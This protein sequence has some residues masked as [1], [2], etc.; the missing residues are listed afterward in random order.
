MC[1][2]MCVL[3]YLPVGN[4]GR[5]HLINCLGKDISFIL[6]PRIGDWSSIYMHMRACFVVV[7]LFFGR[8]M[9]LF[10]RSYWITLFFVLVLLL[11]LSLSSFFAAMS[12]FFFAACIHV[13]FDISPFSFGTGE[14]L[15]YCWTWFSFSVLFVF[16]SSFIAARPLCSVIWIQFNSFLVI[17]FALMSSLKPNCSVWTVSE[18]HKRGKL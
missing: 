14:L 11:D 2:C 12:Y 15:W 5:Y 8:V 1:M 10:V 13:S 3:I 18:L 6:W 17:I 9:L 4:A 16:F 7:V